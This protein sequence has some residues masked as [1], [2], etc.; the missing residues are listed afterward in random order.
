MCI[1]DRFDA[2]APG[3]IVSARFGRTSIRGIKDGDWTAYD[4]VDITDVDSIRFNAGA[5]GEGGLLEVRVGSA[6]GN[7][8]ATKSIEANQQQGGFPG[9]SRPKIV[10]VK[11]NTLGISGPQTL[12]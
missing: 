9:F 5:S 2:S 8:L 3:L 10:P 12:V 11:I 6:T 4:N 1:R 7:V